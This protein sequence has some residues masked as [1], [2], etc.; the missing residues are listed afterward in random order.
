MVVILRLNEISTE[1]IVGICTMYST[2][3]IIAYHNWKPQ[4][5]IIMHRS[6]I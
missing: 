4:E 6:A 1:T 2:G 3:K 5:Y